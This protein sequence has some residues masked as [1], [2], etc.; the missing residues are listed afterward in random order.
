MNIL[1]ATF[2]H[3]A[4]RTF[5]LICSERKEVHRWVVH[6][7]SDAHAR[8][9]QAFWNAFDADILVKGRPLS[10]EVAEA[11]WDCSICH[12]AKHPTIEW[13]SQLRHPGKVVWVAWGGDYYQSFPA[14][15]KSLYLP[16]TRLV[17]VLIGKVFYAYERTALARVLSPS[18]ARMLRERRQFIASV[19]YCSTLLGDQIPC[20]PF[21]KQGVQ[22]LASWY[23]T[24]GEEIVQVQPAKSRSGIVL[25]NSALNTNNHL[26]AIF[27]LR[28]SDLRNERVHTIL[29]YGD[30]RY[31]LLVQGL[32][33]FLLGKHWEPLTVK[34]NPKDYSTFLAR[35]HIAIF[36][37]TR[38][39]GTGNI[40][41]MLFL[42]YTLYLSPVNPL[43]HALKAMGFHLCSTDTLRTEGARVLEASKLAENAELARKIFSE[44]TVNR[45]MD[46]LFCSQ[47]ATA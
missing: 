31:R 11:R 7:N 9:L 39:Q 38:S 47:P 13:I 10:P 46:A 40:A 24:L 25:G 19:D 18:L 41:S 26:D 4:V 8:E 45:S 30:A 27:E 5:A 35:H 20:A 21:M 3:Q 15:Q 12:N 36:Y 37:H 14:L 42:E 44:A 32:G 43:Y 22:F 2:D 17:N 29:S 6:A 16:W 33:K 28:K 1:H 23:N 34:L